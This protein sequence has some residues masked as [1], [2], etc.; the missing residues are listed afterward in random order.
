MA[1]LTKYIWKKR[2]K[3]NKSTKSRYLEGCPQ[4][5]G[6]CMKVYTTKP[7]K[8]NSA[9]RKVAKVILSTRKIILIGIGGHGHKLQEHSTVLIRG[10]KLKDVPGIH[11]KAIRGKYDFL[12]FETFQRRNRRSKFGR[13]NDV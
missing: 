12:M 4:K 10:G 5:K 9:I 6:I 11:Y 8:P 3:K 7:K 2:P 13:K 1:A